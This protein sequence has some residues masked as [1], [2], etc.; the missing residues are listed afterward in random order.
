MDVPIMMKCIGTATIIH[1]YN[2]YSEEKKIECLGQY[3]KLTYFSLSAMTTVIFSTFWHKRNRIFD[4]SSARL[5]FISL[6]NTKRGIFTRGFV[7][8]ENTAFG[9]HLDK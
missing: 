7:T 4:F 9:V 1:Q 8:R 5:I 3:F 6:M 2:F